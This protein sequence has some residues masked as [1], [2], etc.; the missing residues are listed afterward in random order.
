MLLVL[1]WRNDLV[2]WPGRVFPLSREVIQG[3][4]EG[5][6]GKV[7]HS[8]CLTPIPHD[9]ASVGR[10]DSWST[11]SSIVRNITEVINK[12]IDIKEKTMDNLTGN[13]AADE[14]LPHADTYLAVLQR[15]LH[16]PGRIVQQEIIQHFSS[17]KIAGKLQPSAD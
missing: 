12:F 1:L 15:D 6:E 16:A 11:L 10:S 7:G 3:G 8:C 14:E 17:N 4:G 5:S 9:G 13:T 2:A